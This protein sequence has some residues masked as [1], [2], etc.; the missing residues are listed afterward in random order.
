MWSIS[1]PQTSPAAA[2]DGALHSLDFDVGTG[3]TINM[4]KE[5]ISLSPKDLKPSGQWSWSLAHTLSKAK[6]RSQV[7][8]IEIEDHMLNSSQVGRRTR[9]VFCGTTSGI[10]LALASMMPGCLHY[11]REKSHKVKSGAG[12]MQHV[13]A[14]RL[15]P[16]VPPCD[17]H[18]PEGLVFCSST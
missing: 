8:K 15:A 17:R 1:R 16:V 18:L 11:S 6:K 9:T 10:G 5:W 13:D 12:W 7:S 2:A 14:L 3:Y 4:C